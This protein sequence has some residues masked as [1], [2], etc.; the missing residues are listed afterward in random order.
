[1]YFRPAVI[2]YVV[3]HELAHLMEMNHSRHFW[4]LVSRQLPDYVAAKAE[5]RARARQ[6]PD[7]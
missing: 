5:L 3:V 7:I 2:D 4:A 1:M 6:L